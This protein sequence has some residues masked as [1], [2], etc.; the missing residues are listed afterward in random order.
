MS[1]KAKGRIVSEETKKK[2]GLKS[3]GRM[4]KKII[5]I[6]MNDTFLSITEASKFYNINIGSI[7]EVCRGNRKTAGGY[8][9][10]YLND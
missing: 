3:T 8:E 9:W 1:E 2:I 4:S 10:R 6:T 5:N 7:T